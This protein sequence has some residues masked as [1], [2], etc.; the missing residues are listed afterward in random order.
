[1]SKDA[2]IVRKTVANPDLA[3]SIQ[4]LTRD[5]SERDGKFHWHARDDFRFSHWYDKDHDRQWFG[6]YRGGGYYWTI[7]WHDHFWWRDP[8]AG[9]WL[10]YW[11]DHWWWHSPQGV[12]YIFIG[13]Q[14][15]RWNPNANGAV[16][17]PAPAAPSP[18]SGAPAGEG[19]ETSLVSSVPEFNYSA[20]GTRMVAIEG[21][22]LSAYL[23]DPTS[24]DH[25][26]GNRFVKY[27][28]DDV[29]AVAF[30]D[31]SR[32]DP[33]RITLS[34]QD[35]RGAIHQVVLDADGEPVGAGAPRPQPAPPPVV[36]GTPGAP[37]FDAPAVDL[38]PTDSPMPDGN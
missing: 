19:T 31:T 14:Y 12:F 3:R 7:A 13:D 24:M 32:G 18:A 17:V 15:Y 34:V 9:R 29:T 5:E 1:M 10:V 25:D 11:R 37:G 28:G 30:S 8:G 16:L 22:K 36:F 20:D 38:P 23:Y 2:A 26:G 27:L 21:E 35:G 33:L 4:N 6:F